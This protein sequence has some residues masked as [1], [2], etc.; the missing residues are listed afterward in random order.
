[1]L[2]DWNFYH[3]FENIIPEHK[4]ESPDS[5]YIV[6]RQTLVSMTWFLEDIMC[7]TSVMSIASNEIKLT[8]RNT[9]HRVTHVML[10]VVNDRTINNF[11]R[12]VG[13]V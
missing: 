9:K 1:M 10:S 8:E 5:M 4:T 11:L 13:V 3:L 6:K 12:I 7:P 2:Y